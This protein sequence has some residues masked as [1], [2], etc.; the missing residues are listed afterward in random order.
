MLVFR[1]A[2]AA[3]IPLMVGVL[4]ILTTF[5]G[6]RIVNSA[7]DLSVFALNLVTGLGLGLAIDYSLI[8]VSRYREEAAARGKPVPLSGRLLYA[9]GNAQSLLLAVPTGRAG[10]RLA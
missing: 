4:T 1:S 9:I 8:M 7:T 3:L 6:L 2:V 10:Q 5:L